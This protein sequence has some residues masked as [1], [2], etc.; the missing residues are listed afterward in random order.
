[1]PD[2][3]FLCYI[4][5]GIKGCMPFYKTRIKLRANQIIRLKAFEQE[6][7]ESGEKYPSTSGTALKLKINHKR[8]RKSK[9]KYAK[10][11]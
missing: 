11:N 1:M 9:Y 2:E 7:L 8:K 3:Q 5:L 6:I 10:K 4:Q